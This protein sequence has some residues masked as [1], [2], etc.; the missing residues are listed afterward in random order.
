M[1]EKQSI[2]TVVELLDHSFS[3]AVAVSVLYLSNMK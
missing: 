3:I 2:S 1:D